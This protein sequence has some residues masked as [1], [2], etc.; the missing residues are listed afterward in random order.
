MEEYSI[1]AQVLLFGY[2]LRLTPPGV[3]T[4]LYRHVRDRKQQCPDERLHTR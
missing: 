3:E 4:E 2:D 1:A